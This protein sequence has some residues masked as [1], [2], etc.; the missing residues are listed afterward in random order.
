MQAARKAVYV[1]LFLLTTNNLRLS[2]LQSL[3]SKYADDSTLSHHIINITDLDNYQQSI[4]ESEDYAKQHSL[5]PN[6][7]KTFELVIDFSKKQIH[8]NHPLTTMNDNPIQLITEVKIVGY[9]ITN[10]LKP[11]VHI[12]KKIKKANTNIYMLKKLKQH[13]VPKHILV[14]FYNS[15]IL[16][17]L[18]YASEIFI[19]S[20][21][22]ADK[23]A[24]ESVRIRSERIICTKLKPITE[25][26]H[27]R[28]SVLFDSLLK[29]AHPLIP[30]PKQTRHGLYILPPRC[31]TK[32]RQQQFIPSEI[33]NYNKRH[34]TKQ[35]PL[36]HNT[37]PTTSS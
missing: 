26:L 17:H 9:T 5:Q 6:T 7:S 14:T 35:R 15:H 3:F 33:K 2:T 19:H 22:I 11:H 24:L 29:D 10:D 31:R 16:S 18:L 30:Q 36:F 1:S 27:K 4:K 34:N 21:T 37:K 25:L 12:N 20:T 23:T 13:N 32:R 28:A 8:N